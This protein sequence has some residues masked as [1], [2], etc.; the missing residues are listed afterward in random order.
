MR[1]RKI[2]LSILIL[3]GTIPIIPQANA[4]NCNDLELVFIRGS[5][6]IQNENRSFQEFIDSL[7]P[8]LKTTNLKYE[9]IDLDYPAIAVDNFGTILGAFISGGTAYEYGKSM[10]IGVENL[11]NLVN[12]HP[13]KNTKFVLAGYSQGAMVISRI[14][15]ELDSEKIIYAATFG[16][17]KLYLPEGKGIYPAACRNQNLS[18]Y[19]KYVPDCYAHEGLLGSYR[20][21]EPE[22]FVGKLGTWCNKRDIMCSS[23]FSLSDHVT[24]I[25]DGLYDDAAKIIYNKITQTFSIEN[26]LTSEHDTA[27][28]IDSTGSM[29][30]LIEKYKSEA[31]RLATETLDNGGRVA[32]YDYRDLADPYEPNRHCDFETCTIELIKSELDKI[33]VDG[34]G[35]KPESLL[36]ASFHIMNELNWR[37]GA[38]KSVIVLTDGG[39]HA[40]DLDGT[41][42]LD[43]VK[44]SQSIDP[45]N[46][47]VITNPDSAPDYIELTTQTDGKIETSFDQLNLLTDFIMSRYDSLPRVE[48]EDE[49]SETPTITIANYNFDDTLKID[50]ETNAEKILVIINDLPLGFTTENSIELT[51]LDIHQENTIRLVPIKSDR[52]GQAAELHFDLIPSVPNTGTAFH[53][54]T[55]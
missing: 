38:T 15:D 21:Y 31:I 39:F 34:G 30:N 22:N 36:S 37:Y 40:P 8:K 51:D 6:E 26:K 9:F 48:P 29:T 18:D 32:L 49:P 27:I 14:L 55:K 11:K 35:D 4:E 20:P 45:V 41:S 13:C 2:L 50:F 7:D 23:H 54:Y 28:L 52:R 53:P 1:T 5:G 24:Y 16:D 3:L 25:E 43:V 17:P 10:D 44:L 42:L 12:S 46:F 33:E 19:R 47:Y